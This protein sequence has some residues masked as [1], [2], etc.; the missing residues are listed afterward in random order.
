MLAL[1][2]SV[3]AFPDSSG[4]SEI[5]YFRAKLRSTWEEALLVLAHCRQE[6]HKTNI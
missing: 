5:A 4:F 2:L 3:S 1:I 6:H